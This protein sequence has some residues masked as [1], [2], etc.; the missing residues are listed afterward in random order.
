MKFKKS[1]LPLCL[2]V[3][4][5]LINHP[6]LLKADDAKETKNF[7]RDLLYSIQAISDGEFDQASQIL[8]QCLKQNPQSAEVY[9][10]KGNLFERQQK[11]DDAINA[12]QKAIEVDPDFTRSYY[13]LG[14]LLLVQ[15]RAVKASEMF[16]QLVRREPR[17]ISDFLRIGRMFILQ[18]DYLT[19]NR[20]LKMAIE[21]KPTANAYNDLSVISIFEK[22]FDNSIEYALKAVELDPKLASSYNNLGVAYANGKKDFQK[23]IGYYKQAI[24]LNPKYGTAYQNLGE[25]QFL[26]GNLDDAVKSYQKC[27]ELDPASAQ[28]NYGLA[29]V[30]AGQKKNAEAIQ[31]LGLALKREPNLAQLAKQDPHFEE[32]RK[33]PGFDAL[34]GNIPTPQNPADTAMPAL[35]ATSQ[36]QPQVQGQ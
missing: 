31:R 16:D 8:D 33:E 11:I 7:S 24:E 25:S 9:F 10:L 35:D 17:F 36:A 28:A 29:A 30:F 19:A 32:L 3:A 21:V 15:D 6:A 12:Y 18:K 22:D 4:F 34:I 5:F 26:A 20:Y 1:F 23:A 27:L 2:M 14:V 13:N